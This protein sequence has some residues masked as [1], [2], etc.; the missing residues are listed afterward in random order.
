MPKSGTTTTTSPAALIDERIASF[1]D[2]R[3]PMLARLRAVITA[4]N[5][6]IVEEWKWNVPVWSCHGI[7]CTG[8]VYKSVVKLT[9]AH[10]AALGDPAG[11]FN[12]SLD[13]KTRRAIDI[14]EGDPIDTKALTALVRAAL[15]R[16]R[17]HQPSRSQTP[18]EN[19]KGSDPG[20]GPQA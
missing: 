12:S 20:S 9:F 6:G 1:D 18:D 16:N 14:R 11:L 15:A 7:I 8:E 4:A 2:W 3:G 13:G 5:A 17:A 19:R 10:G